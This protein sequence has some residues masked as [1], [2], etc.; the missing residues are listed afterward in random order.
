MAGK[1]HQD[2]IVETSFRNPKQLKK[3]LICILIV[4]SSGLAISQP[5]WNA[6]KSNATFNVADTSLY[7]APFIQPVNVPGWE[8]GLFMT[9]DGMHLYST[10]LPLDAFS[11]IT[12]LQANPICFDFTPYYRPPLLDIDTNTN[13][14]GCPNF[15][16]S[17]IIITGK[18]TPQSAF[19]P[20]SA[21]NLRTAFSF[22]GGAQ[23][24][25]MNADT[26]DLFVYTRDGAGTQGVDI[27]LLRNVPVNPDTA[28]AV[29]L[30]STPA[31][32]DN[33][34]IERLNDSSLV[35]LFDRDRYIYYSTSNDNGTT[36]ATPQL[37]ADELNDQAPYDVQPHLWYDGTDWW[38]YFC[39]DNGSFVRGI[40]RSRQQTPGNWSNWMA[41]ELVIEGKTI[42]GG[43]GTIYGVGE[44][45]LSTWGDL[46]FVVVYGDAGSSDSTD[47][48][49]CDPWFLPR[50]GSPLTGI[51]QPAFEHHEMEISYNSQ[52]HQLYVSHVPETT[53]TQWFIND[54]LGRTCLTGVLK[55]N[56]VIEIDAL[57]KGYYVFNA[58]TFK[59]YSFVKY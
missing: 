32:E 40:Y 53:S 6:I 11:W 36:W 41:K 24:V 13:I 5:N 45:T 9:R 56:T 47:R 51:H 52:L 46:S 15:M 4:L 3:V 44:P 14:F 58:G 18:S 54:V 37:V 30:F 39:A 8:D 57:P 31:Y 55:N 33:P 29:A 7:D 2:E 28:G 22:D 48:F 12:A 20:W 50:K 23:G 19:N 25:L 1:I 43:Y 26:F 21:S 42:T 38:V 34:H 59:G 49:D 35:I 16:Q 17:D 27:M 10:Y